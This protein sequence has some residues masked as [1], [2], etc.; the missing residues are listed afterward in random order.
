MRDV[1]DT[2]TDAWTQGTFIGDQRPVARVTVQHPTMRLRSYSL[3]STFTYKVLNTTV[4]AI[5]SVIKLQDGGT[6]TINIPSSTETTYKLDPKHPHR[7]HNTYADFL[8]SRLGKPMEIPTVKSVEWT[9]SV[10]QDVA[11]CTITMWNTKPQPYDEVAPKGS[12]PRPFDLDYPGY[13]TY[14]RGATQV[15][16]DQWGYTKNEWFGYLL[17]DNIIRT[18]EGYGTD[19]DQPPELDPYLV[20]T[21]TW[22]I[23]TVTY[24]GVTMTIKCRDL[25]RLLLEQMYYRP[26][27]PKDFYSEDWQ[28]WGDTTPTNN[29]PGKLKVTPDDSSNTP[30]L[31]SSSTKAGGIYGH[32]LKHAFDG[33]SNTYWLSIGNDKPSRRFAYEWVQCK[34]NNQTVTQVKIQAKKKGYTAYISVM[35][36]GQWQGGRKINYHEDGI[37]RNGADINYV[38]TAKV[39]S[40]GVITIKLKKGGYKK[41]QKVRVTFGNLQYF[42]YGTYRYRAGIRDVSV[43]GIGAANSDD[44][45]LTPGPVGSNPGRYRDYT[46]LV[47]LFCAWGGF[48]WPKGGK[49]RICNPPGT[50]P[51]KDLVNF[52]DYR[53]VS[54]AKM[55]WHTLG[56]GVMGRVWGD[57]AQTGTTNS[58]IIDHSDFD[59]KSL[60]DC[61]ST[62]RDQIGFMFYIDETGG[63]VWRPPNIY[64]RGN[65]AGTIN[66]KP[67]FRPGLLHLLTETAYMSD[68]TV[69]I[70]SK[71]V[72]EM[73]FVGT[74][75]GKKGTMAP[76]YNPNPTGMRRTS[77]WTDVDF[78][79]Q[80]EC[81]VMAD[82]LSLRQL[83]TYRTTSMKIPANP[84]IQ[85][86][87][88]ARVVE[89]I[90]SE[91]YIHYIRSINSSLDMESGQYTF[92]LETNWLGYDPK[93]KWL[94]QI[95]DLKAA[96][97]ANMENARD[98][99]VE[100]VSR[101]MD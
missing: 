81:E 79:T 96:T 30:W 57:F 87:D 24:N 32:P 55:D 49:Q 44:D 92:D 76:G 72:R 28:N 42:P 56:K 101:K 59:K 88:Q 20:Q 66:D 83:F 9:R 84:A 82:F 73:Y 29:N 12:N 67:G 19:Q 54:P 97:Q 37:G 33:S 27:T 74:I 99:T 13:Y 50:D 94:F 6:E 98:A 51:L 25:G 75:D 39:D 15:A 10:D 14:D 78:K 41:V 70:D 71:N 90:S 35:V 61:I 52:D 45:K 22:L 53:T 38:K 58:E 80:R 93:T 65:I 34:V 2:I 5:K 16:K 18:Y 100:N 48:F 63:V 23:D 77:G 64:N 3:M 26:V 43:Y 40:E 11:E 7:V 21:G 8:F 47:K 95:T 36:D 31:N 17:P 91:G 46:D 68:L 1:P 69:N 86:D 89:R 60:M 4:P 62:I 85:I